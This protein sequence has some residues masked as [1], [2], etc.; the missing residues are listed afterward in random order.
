MTN[1]AGETFTYEV[2]GG[3]LLLTK[4]ESGKTTATTNLLADGEKDGF[5]IRQWEMEAVNRARDTSKT[6]SDTGLEVNTEGVDEVTN[7]MLLDR[8]GQP[9][10]ADDKAIATVT[11]QQDDSLKYTAR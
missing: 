8:N 4:N 1:T 6:Q 3:T 9:T 10:L 5:I 7:G 11:I 2:S